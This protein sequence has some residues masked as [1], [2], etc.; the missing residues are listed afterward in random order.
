MTH[1]HFNQIS[2]PERNSDNKGE[3]A[4]GRGNAGILHASSITF[5]L[6]PHLLVSRSTVMLSIGHM[7]CTEDARA[8][9]ALERQKICREYVRLQV[10]RDPDIVAGQSSLPL[11][12]RKTPP[13]LQQTT[14]SSPLSLATPPLTPSHLRARPSQHFQPPEPTLRFVCSSKPLSTRSHPLALRPHPSAD[15]SARNSAPRDP[16]TPSLGRAGLLGEEEAMLSISRVPAPGPDCDPELWGAPCPSPSSTPRAELPE[17]L[18]LLA[19]EPHSS[20]SAHG[21]TDVIAQ[22]GHVSRSRRAARGATQRAEPRPE[23]LGLAAD[24]VCP[25]PGLSSA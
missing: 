17:P 1:S 3:E 19:Q 15:S 5:R 2:G 25:A 20:P 22:G 13:C 23:V 24:W 10:Q 14:G 12:G 21:R 6:P 11:R 7:V 18:R 16:E 8:G 4:G 9:V